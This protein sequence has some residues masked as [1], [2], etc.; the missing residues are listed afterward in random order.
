MRCD[1]IKAAG[2]VRRVALRWVANL[3]KLRVMR[4]LCAAL[5]IAPLAACG[6]GDKPPGTSVDAPADTTTVEPPA[7]TPSCERRPQTAADT[8]ATPDVFGDITPGTLAN[9][10]PT[11]RWFTTGVRM[12]TSSIHLAR[13]GDQIIID[14]D[15]AAKIANNDVV[16]QRETFDAGGGAT[17][18]LARRI[19]NRAS[20]G[21][22]RF[23]RALCDGTN[24]RV[25]SAKLIYATYNAGEVEHDKLPLVGQ[26]YGQDWAPTYTLNVRVVDSLAYV[27][28]FDG[29]YIIDV[30]NPAAPV[31]RGHYARAGD[32]YSNDLKIVSTAAGKRYALIADTP[33]DVVDVTNPAAPVFVT[34]IREEA[35]TLFTETRNGKTLAYF[36]NYDATCPVYD[37]TDP[38]VPKRVGTFKTNGPFVHDLSVE[39]GVAYLN[40]WSEFVAVDFTTPAQPKV[41]GRWTDTPTA[42]SH[43]NWTTT[44]GGRHLAIHGE[45]EYGA[46]LN[47]VD[48]D[49]GSPTFM[50]PIGEYRTRDWISIHNIMAFGNKAYFTY[51]QDGVR[52]LDLSTPTTPRLVGYHNTWD[53]QADYATAEFFDGAVGLD[54]DLAKKLIYV[55]DTRGLLILRD[56]TP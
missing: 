11:G 25:C 8:F 39:N 20:D 19:S 21:S 15:Q 7:F 10:D 41:V 44:I 33:V 31:Q 32:G 16:F 5:L 27:I 38:A 40:A 46:H 42:T 50:Q 9:W 29:L 45:E 35:H 23:D 30:S 13:I 34:T 54:V 3:G 2:C 24:C 43:S 1:R 22:L 17:G 28:R 18:I 14:R 49:V 51:Y 47:V 26:F 52:V 12:G 48:L 36:G 6:G 56:E 55:A 37:V 53:P 4:Y